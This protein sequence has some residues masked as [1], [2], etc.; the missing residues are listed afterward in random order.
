[1]KVSICLTDGKKN[2]KKLAKKLKAH[3]CKFMVE[4]LLKNSLTENLNKDLGFH[5]QIRLKLS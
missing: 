4:I 3:D 2:S 5:S 1:M